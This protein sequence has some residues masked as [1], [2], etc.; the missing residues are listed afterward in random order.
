VNEPTIGDLAAEALT[1]RW[2][3]L[4]LFEITDSLQ[5]R[6]R[7]RLEVKNVWLRKRGKESQAV[8]PPRR[9][10]PAPEAQLVPLFKALLEAKTPDGRKLAAERIEKLGLPALPGVR[11]LL[12]SLKTDQECQAELKAL[13]ARLALIVAEARFASDSVPPTEFFRRNVEGLQGKPITEDTFMD[14]LRGTASA[15]PNGVRGVKLT[16]E[17]VPDDTGALLVVTLIAD[18][19]PRE[20][21][22]PQL[23]YG[24]R[25]QLDKQNLGG[26]TGGL[27]GI[28]QKVGLAD[29][30]WS[31]FSKN[32]RT[33][34]EAQPDQYLLIQAHCAEAR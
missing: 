15:L 1:K 30:D 17:R 13:V 9:I 3:Q 32:L 24:S 19:S 5:A 11:K 23:T 22:S 27:A 26:G 28:G 25:L 18:R 29:I 2:K 8:P 20:G 16:L 12:K 7:Q 21:L 10:T 34:L 31:G 14:L 4:K 33:V 6:E